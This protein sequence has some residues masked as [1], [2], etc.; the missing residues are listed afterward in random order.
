MAAGSTLYCV[1]RTEYYNTVVT[2]LLCSRALP[3]ADRVIVCRFLM[4]CVMLMAAAS[5]LHEWRFAS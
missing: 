4:R 2:R 5:S 3:C 1:V